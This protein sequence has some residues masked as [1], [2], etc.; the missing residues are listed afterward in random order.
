MPDIF[1]NGD[2]ELVRS[3]ILIR[4]SLADVWDFGPCSGKNLLRFVSIRLPCPWK[5]EKDQT[6]QEGSRLEEQPDED[7]PHKSSRIAR[8]R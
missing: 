2:Q 7:I 3:G 1:M 4:V 5:S 6:V 8:H